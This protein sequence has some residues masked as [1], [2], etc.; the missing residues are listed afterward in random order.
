MRRTGLRLLVAVVGVAG[1]AACSAGNSEDEAF[2]SELRLAGGAVEA[3]QF[4]SAKEMVEASDFV[5]QGRFVGAKG[6]R[7]I[8]GDAAED[9][10]FLAQLLFEVDRVV[11][12]PDGDPTLI[13]EFLIGS[14]SEKE[15][16]VVVDVLQEATP[17]SGLVMFVRHKRGAQE[18]GLYRPI[19][20]LGLW[21]EHDGKPNA[22]LSDDESRA[23]QLLRSA[24]SPDDLSQ[25]ASWIATQPPTEAIAPP[26][27][28]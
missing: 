27:L 3:E 23:G 7:L 20:S 25:L 21:A 15:A 2:W 11:N 16:Q 8:Q 12:G 19:N 26:K 17:E 24:G 5:V 13:V 28:P 18:A 6:V 1:G 10:V 14:A 9:Q 22:P 4:N